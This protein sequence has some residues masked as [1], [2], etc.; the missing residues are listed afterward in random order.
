MGGKYWSPYLAGACAGLVLVLSVWISGNYFG[1]STSFV[2]SAGLIERLFS[3]ERV[4]EM[5]YFTKTTPKIDWQWM[6]VVGVFF[7]ALIAA[8]TSGTFKVQALPDMWQQRFGSNIAFRGLIAFVGG[9]V[10]M[11]GARL[12]DGCP[13]GHGLS[14][15]S[16]LALSGFIALV[17][18]FVG[19][20]I[21][22]N[23]L[24]RRGKK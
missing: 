13:S 1:A 18:F 20:M 8:K 12:A 21:S 10:A 9:T 22:A 24:Y 23:L 3:A 6:F 19:G 17:C 2:R 15:L 4:A 16:Q 14:G 11:F 5:E 7:G